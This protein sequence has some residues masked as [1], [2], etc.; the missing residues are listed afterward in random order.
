MSDKNPWAVDGNEKETDYD[1]IKEGNYTATL[2][3]FV[4]YTDKE[5]KK[6]RLQWRLD[7]NRVISQFFSFNEK[8]VKWLSWQLGIIECYSGSEIRELGLNTADEV[9][10]Y[11]ENKLQKTNNLIVDLEIQHRTYN[12]KTSENALVKEKINTVINHAP[13]KKQSEPPSLDDCELP[14]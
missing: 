2:D 7:N 8:S 1:L 3:D 5:P 12:G 6:L 11:V 10:V 13:T 14:F 9:L 4:F